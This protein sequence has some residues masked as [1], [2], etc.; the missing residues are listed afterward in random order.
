VVG[1]EA[2]LRWQ[3]PEHGAVSPASFL[4]LAEKSRLIIPIGNWV[5]DE[6]CRQ[7]SAWRAAVITT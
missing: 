3:H 5:I 1:A 4:P 2:L 7:M 6:A